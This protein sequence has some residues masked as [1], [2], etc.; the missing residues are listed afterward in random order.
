M[1]SSY[2]KN[3]LIVDDNLDIREML[4]IIIEHFGFYALI[5]RDIEEAFNLLRKNFF[6]VAIINYEM[7]DMAGKELIRIIKENYSYLK[8]WGMSFA[9][10]KEDFYKTGADFFIEKP[11]NLFKL[12]ALLKTI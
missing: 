7:S 2:S 9:D 5:A 4:K 1:S 3:I 11:F 10:K 8:V 6:D 12:R